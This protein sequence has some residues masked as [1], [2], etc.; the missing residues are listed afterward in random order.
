MK[1]LILVP[2]IAL[3]MIVSANA[4]DDKKVEDQKAKTE[5]STDVQT[6][7]E[8]KAEVER[9]EQEKRAQQAREE[10]AKKAAAKKEKEAAVKEEEQE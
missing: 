5:A 10:E 3:G 1:K 6:Q 2:A 8:I 4:Q 7:E 9:L